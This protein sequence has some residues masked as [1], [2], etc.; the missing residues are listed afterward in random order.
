MCSIKLLTDKKEA[1]DVLPAVYK[2]DIRVQGELNHV[3]FNRRSGSHK[4]DYRRRHAV[5]DEESEYYVRLS[6]SVATKHAYI[7][8]FVLTATS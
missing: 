1:S 5:K 7:A 4:T 3:Y 2:R 8:V 6:R